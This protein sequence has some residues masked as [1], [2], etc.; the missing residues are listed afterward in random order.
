M[1][2]LLF[3]LPDEAIIKNG[4]NKFILRE[5]TK[6]LLPELINERRNKIGFTTPENE[7]FKKKSDD[8]LTF[9]PENSLRQKNM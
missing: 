5:S 7:W 9:L 2:E 8:I 1:T 3:S 4:W 6:D